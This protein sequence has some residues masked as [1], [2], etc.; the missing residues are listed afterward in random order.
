MQFK[1]LCFFLLMS[2][3]ISAQ[4]SNY[5][6]FDLKNSVQIKTR[7]ASTWKPA[8][9]GLPVGLTDSI[10]IAAGSSIRILDTRTNEVFRSNAIGY[11]RIK[12]S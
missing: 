9:K 3:A 5:E 7:N 4:T 1:I 6:I 10:H 8:N 12:D 2:I 11:F